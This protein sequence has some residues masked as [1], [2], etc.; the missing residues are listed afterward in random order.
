MGRS[1]SPKDVASPPSELKT[2]LHVFVQATEY[3]NA[4]IFPD[5]LHISNLGQNT[6]VYP[7]TPPIFQ[8]AIASHPDHVRLVIVCMTISHRMNRMRNDTRYHELAGHF[9]HYRGQLIRSLS[10][11]IWGM[12]N[13]VIA[14]MLTLLLVDAQQGASPHYR[15]HL[16]GVRKI[17]MLRGGIQS[18]V[19]STGM[20][21]LLLFI[22]FTVVMGDTSSP[23]SNLAMVTSDL[24]DLE[25]MIKQYGHRA[26]AFGTYPTA[27]LTEIIKINHFRVRA[28]KSDLTGTNDITDEAYKVLNRICNFSPTQWSESKSASNSEWLLLGNIHQAAVALYCI[29]SLQSVAIL[30]Q[31][32]TLQLTC[33][34]YAQALQGLLKDALPSPRMKRSIIW[35]LVVLG[36]EAVNDTG[37]RAF[38]REHLPELSH[39]TG[40][41]VPLMARSLL[42]RF[43]ASNETHWDACFDQP[44][45]FAMHMSVDVS[46]LR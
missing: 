41:Y 37:I 9:F 39:S 23:A 1:A 29:R 35:D 34:Y 20:E 46:G 44:Y 45:T 25:F 40:T 31:N 12:S 32:H 28:W 16:D 5:L 4:C 27:L 26:F 2:D 38:L 33:T 14:G 21:P 19:R 22:V 18:L 11:D 30:P 13:L 42:E 6:A 10:N 36:V 15:C 8:M 17:I 3:Y 24:E 43:W 7:I